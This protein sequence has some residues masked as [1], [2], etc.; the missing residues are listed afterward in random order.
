MAG[1]SGYAL[2]VLAHMLIMPVAAEN[3]L[4][5][6]LSTEVRVVHFADLPLGHGISCHEKRIE[7]KVYKDIVQKL[8]FLLERLCYLPNTG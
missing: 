7:L 5:D 6:V 1:D 3:R 8:W 4:P 2:E